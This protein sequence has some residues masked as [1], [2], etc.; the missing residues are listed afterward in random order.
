MAGGECT[1][2]S[3]LSCWAH[4]VEMLQLRSA[5]FDVAADDGMMPLSGYG[6]GMPMA[7]AY[8]PDAYSMPGTFRG[9]TVAR[10][11]TGQHTLRCWAN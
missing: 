5:A 1:C 7:Y 4:A 9:A 10:G 3:C 11:K 8:P 6:G 2:G